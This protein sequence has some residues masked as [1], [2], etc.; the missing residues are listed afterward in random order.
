MKFAEEQ[1]VQTE[2]EEGQNGGEEVANEKKDNKEK[3]K[4]IQD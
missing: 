3:W 1:K 2:L 4:R